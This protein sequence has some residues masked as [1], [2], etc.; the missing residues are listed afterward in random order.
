MISEKNLTVIK[1]NG[2]KE[3]F[4][5]NKITNAIIKA[6]IKIGYSEYD[7][8]YDI[9]NDVMANILYN[10]EDSI[11]IKDIERITETILM[12][13]NKKLAREYVG[14]RSARDASR[15][16]SS[17]LVKK[18][19]G[20][21]N[22]ND[23]EIIAENANKNAKWL[24]I[25]R[26]LLAGT[27]AKE[28][29]M[30]LH[31]IPANV[32]KY[33]L[34]N[35]LHW[36]DMDYS[37]LFDM[38]NCMLID[39]ETMFEKGFIMNNA[40]ISTP[41]S[42]KVACTVLTQIIAAVASN[43]YG[44]QTINRIDEKLAKYVTK[45]YIKIIKNKI[46]DMLSLYTEKIINGEFEFIGINREEINRQIDEIIEKYNLKTIEEINDFLPNF[47]IDICTGTGKNVK[48]KISKTVI[49]NSLHDI[50]KDVYDGIQSI[51]YQINTI[52]TTNGQT[53]FVSISFGLG[54]SLESRMIQKSILKVRIE[55]I[56]ERHLTPVFPKLLFIQCK[57]INFYK[58]DPNYDIKK[59][60]MICSSLRMYPDILNYENICKLAGGKVVYKD[61]EK[62]VVDIEKSTG[63]KAPMGCRSFLHRW[64]DPE[65][66]EPVLDENGKEIYDGRQN[67]GVIS[68]NLV[69]IALEAR[70]YSDDIN[71]R[72]NYFFNKLD[73]V[74]EVAHEGLTYRIE[75][76]LNVKA[77][78][79]PILYGNSRLG[80]YGAMG[81]S[82]DPDETVESMYTNYRASV[83]LG[84]VG[85][86]E[87]VMAI[88]DGRMFKNPTLIEK[89]KAIM[90][91]LYNATVEWKKNS[92][93]AFSVYGTPAENLMN[94]FIK[95]D[96]NRFG[97]VKGILD[98]DWYTNSFHLDV[99]QEA[100]A[101]EKIDYESNFVEFSPGG[102]TTMIDCNSLKNNP[103]ALEPL[104]NYSYEH[105]KIGY[106]SINVREDKC[107]K[108]D[109]TGEFIPTENG[110]ECPNCGNTERDYQ[111]VLRRISG[112]LTEASS[113]PINHS[114]KSEIDCRV[115]HY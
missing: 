61:K 63:F 38:H 96:Y 67:A 79:A 91:H 3:K 115:T 13:Y 57:G 103:M 113:R 90:E 2:N 26:D 1:R 101:F 43:Q 70:E 49:E 77:E 110:Y 78:V 64:T 29:T 37:P 5:R 82:L 54:T 7:D 87:T 42:F 18:I 44:G 59:L 85:L 10:Y 50:E 19:K 39:Y 81:C 104:W 66:G 33:V 89:G 108:C 14:Y 6:M 102:F 65:T 31:Y 99:E 107:F 20:L 35:Y 84:Y 12:S 27:V 53:P 25:Q 30:D 111:S 86:H 56:G 60:A 51:E 73:E 100:N 28:I 93:Y 69:K 45:S 83:S 21:F 47:I 8:A 105:S 41:K 71:E 97:E 114:K 58:E 109:F 52:S 34:N 11:D 74:L 112:Y 106:M 95:P 22:Q 72:E 24:H 68:V 32:E 80:A 75:R 92:K 36:H 62:R 9:T 16:R 88:Y 4:D 23:P 98:K 55:G 94:K 15:M 48:Y 17:K 46:Y 76:L 40:L